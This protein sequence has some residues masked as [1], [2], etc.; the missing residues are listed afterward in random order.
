[1]VQ[2]KG[3]LFIKKLLVSKLLKKAQHI[4]TFSLAL[5]LFL[6]TKIFFDNHI[7]FIDK[8]RYRQLSSRQNSNV[9]ELFS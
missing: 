1:M 8:D 4:S 7:P 6:I 2:Q 5:H 9:L 3:R